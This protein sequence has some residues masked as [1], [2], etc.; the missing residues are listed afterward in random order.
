MTIVSYSTRVTVRVRVSPYLM[1]FE[2]QGRVHRSTRHGT[3][4]TW[5]FPRRSI[6]AELSPTPQGAGV[7]V[8]SSSPHRRPALITA[9]A[10]LPVAR[11]C[12]QPAQFMPS[13]SALCQKPCS[14]FFALRAA[15]A[16]SFRVRHI[17]RLPSKKP[18]SWYAMPFGKSRLHSGDPAGK[19][20]RPPP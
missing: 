4:W 18:G 16:A 3:S 10:L 8:A 12:A 7:G 14:P 1:G 6:T 19:A 9:P 17:S 11:R 20:S 13:Q 15:R 2:A 5:T